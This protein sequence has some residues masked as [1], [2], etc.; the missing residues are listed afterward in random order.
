[1]AAVSAHGRRWKGACFHE[2]VDSCM[3]FACVKPYTR[4][5]SSSRA[6]GGERTRRGERVV[7]GRFTIALVVHNILFFIVGVASLS[8]PVRCVLVSLCAV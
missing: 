2:L 1:M 5:F 6:R 8:F 4:T 3:Y 7:Y